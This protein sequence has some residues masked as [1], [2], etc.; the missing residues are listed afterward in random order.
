LEAY[1]AHPQVRLCFNETNSGSTFAQW[2]RGF[3]LARGRHLWIAESDD[4]AEPDHLEVL[5]K[6]IS[7]QPDTA[8]AYCAS[9]MVDE[10]GKDLGVIPDPTRSPDQRRFAETFSRPGCDEL[11]SQ[12]LS[13]CNEIPNASS[14]LLSAEAVRRA[15]P[16][17]AWYRLTGDWQFYARVLLCGSVTFTPIPR[18]RFRCHSSSARERHQ[19][20][21]RRWRELCRFYDWALRLDLWSDADRVEI[22]HRFA[23]YL[24]R[25]MRFW[26]MRVG[27]KIVVQAWPVLWIRYSWLRLPL[28][29]ATTRL[30]RERFL[31]KG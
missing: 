22:R 12:L 19:R 6:C 28:L 7:Q 9:R 18:N 5:V 24:I 26:R 17:D 21:G 10:Q 11:R 29:R 23:E 20:S 14:A 1:R 4:D 31:P 25:N 27:S 8:V 13:V 16:A 2:N 3:S 15:G 30:V